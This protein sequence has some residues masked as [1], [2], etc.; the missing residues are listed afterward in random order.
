MRGTTTH[1][2]QPKPRSLGNGEVCAPKAT[3][4]YNKLS[5]LTTVLLRKAVAI[6]HSLVARCRATSPNFTQRTVK[7]TDRPPISAALECSTRYPPCIRASDTTS[8]SLVADQCKNI[9][10]SSLTK[11]SSSR[12]DQC[13]DSTVYSA[14]VHTDTRRPWETVQVTEKRSNQESTDRC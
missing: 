7:Y 14:A 9:P 5:D 8:H 13:E 11:C 4:K 12:A 3:S 1:H 6:H 10:N 2:A